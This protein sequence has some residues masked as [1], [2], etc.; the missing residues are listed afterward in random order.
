MYSVLTLVLGITYLVGVVV[1]QTL[2]VRLTGQESA[3]AV[4]ASTLVI[5]ALFGP[6]RRQVQSLIDRR[7]FRR[8]YDA[9]QVLAQ[10]AQQVQQQADL[11]ALAA[12]IVGVVQETLEPDQVR[13]WIVQRP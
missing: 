9:Q 1:L 4:V 12:D 13:I 10:F 5:A 11:D 2:F 3:L 8:T 6:L 7:F